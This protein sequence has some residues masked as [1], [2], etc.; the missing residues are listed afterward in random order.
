MNHRTP[1]DKDCACACCYELLKKIEA[2]EHDLNGARQVADTASFAAV[3]AREK[4]DH[5]KDQLAA[6]PSTAEL[7]EEIRQLREENDRL[8]LPGVIR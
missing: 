4:Y 5:I 1:D 7:R 8:R 2:L 3:R 6:M